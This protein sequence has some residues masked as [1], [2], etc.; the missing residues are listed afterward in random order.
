MCEPKAATTSERK[1][2]RGHSSEDTYQPNLQLGLGTLSFTVCFAAWGLISAFAALPAW[3]AED[4]T[5]YR[6]DNQDPAFIEK[7]RKLSSQR[8]DWPRHILNDEG[9][10]PLVGS[11]VVRSAS[12]WCSCPPVNLALRLPKQHGGDNL[13]T[14]L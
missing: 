11:F 4:M 2:L 6:G 13:F 14:T 10:S 5:V 8:Q 7:I 1:P 12:I 9:Y 3:L